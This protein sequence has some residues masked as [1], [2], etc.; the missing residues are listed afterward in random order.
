MKRNY[1][2]K[3]RFIIEAKRAEA[4]ENKHS[5]ECCEI[6]KDAL[7]KKVRQLEKEADDL[8]GDMYAEI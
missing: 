3:Q 6:R 2:E 5:A 4:K 1:H 7:L 8:E